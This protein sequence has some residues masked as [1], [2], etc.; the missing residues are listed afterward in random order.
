M[1]V[2]ITKNSHGHGQDNLENVTVCTVSIYITYLYFRY[3]S[4]SFSFVSLLDF[5]LFSFKTKKEK[6]V[7]I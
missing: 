3:I 7:F 6:R 1:H 4:T 5:C 2:F